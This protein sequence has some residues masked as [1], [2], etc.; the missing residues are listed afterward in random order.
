MNVATIILAAGASRRLGRPKQ[1]VE[2]DGRTLLVRAITAA[3]GVGE[4]FVVLGA[5]AEEIRKEL[6]GD[7]VRVVFNSEWEEGIA[8]SIRAGVKVALEK[9]ADGVLLMA[10]DQ[11]RVT[12]EHLG[13]LRWSFEEC[14]GGRIVASE[15][16]G[17]FGIPAV[18]PRA[19]FATLLALK[20]DEGARK[21]LRNAGAEIVA[22]KLAGGELDIDTPGD[23]AKL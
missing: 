12:A 14:G 16:A 5:G 22:V 1:L 23:L 21:I 17:V 13:E 9:E 15:Y 3:Q 2:Y 20:G 10:C 8:S 19:E 6:G 11:P 7:A 18:F 4:V